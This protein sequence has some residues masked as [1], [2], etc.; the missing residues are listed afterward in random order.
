MGLDPQQAQKLL[1]LEVVA[2]LEATV[3]FLLR[4]PPRHLYILTM[5]GLAYNNTQSAQLLVEDLAKHTFQSSPKIRAIMEN[6]TDL[7]TEEALDH[8]LDIRAS[9]LPIKLQTN[10]IRC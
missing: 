3:F 9:Y 8:I 4:Q 2:S 6:Y 7:P 5:R 1:D 10:T